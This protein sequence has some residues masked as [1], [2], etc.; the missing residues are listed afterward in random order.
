MIDH[1]LKCIFVHQPRTAGTSI[2][3]ALCGTD[4]WFVE[5][6]TKH[7][8]ATVAKDVYAGYWHDYLKFSVVREQQSWLESLYATFGRGDG[9]PKPGEELEPH[10]CGVG[11]MAVEDYMKR[12][13]FLKHE[14]GFTADQEANTAGVDFILRFESLQGDWLELCR[15]LGISATLPWMNRR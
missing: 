15:I 8:A 7:L 6:G 2:E 4:W 10:P 11:P 13:R 14:A 1:S 9:K 5:P 3:Y 12:P